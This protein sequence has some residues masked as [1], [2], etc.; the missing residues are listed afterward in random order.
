MINDTIYEVAEEIRQWAETIVRSVD[1]DNPQGWDS[2]LT[3]M[4]AMVSSVLAHRLHSLGFTSA[5]LADSGD[6]TFVIY[7]G[8]VLDLTATQFGDFDRIMVE[9]FERVKKTTVM[10]NE[11]KHLPKFEINPWDDAELELVG[12]SSK[13]QKLMQL[14]TRGV[15][16]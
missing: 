16:L 9:Q 4:C 3:N 7:E 6:H 2:E 8:Y 14:H 13:I 11:I 5:K 1:K 12:D 10:W 15:G